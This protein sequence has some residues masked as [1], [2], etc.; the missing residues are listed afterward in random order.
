M[1]EIIVVGGG[2]G[3]YASAIR[4]SQLGAKVTLVEAAELGGTCVNRGCIP[5]K[6]WLKAA[7]VKET[8]RRAAEFGV[9][10]DFKSLNL[11]TVVAR[12]NGIGSDIRMGMQGLLANYRVNVVQG[13]A[14]FTGPTEVVVDGKTHSAD[15]V[16]LATGSKIDFPNISGLEDAALPVTQLFDLTSLPGS[17]LIPGAGVI[18]VEM[19]QLLALMGVK[20]T[21][22]AD[23]SRI[24]PGED[25]DVGQRIGQAIKAQG[26]DVVTRRK[27]AAVYPAEKGYLCDL[28]GEGECS[29]VVDKIV[30]CGR[31]PNSAGLGLET[32]G[33]R[34]AEDGAVWV[35]DTLQT[36]TRGL[37]AIGDVTGGRMLSHAASA[38]A[39]F[40]A[41]NAM[42]GSAKFP[43]HLVPR[44]L[45][46]LPEA[47][48]VGFTEEEAEACGK[49][50]KVG[51]F[52]FSINALAMTEG[53]QPGAVKVVSDAK[54][55]EILGVHIVG[56]HATELIGEAVTA[57][58]LES[59]TRELALSIRMHPT[60]SEA[61]V[62][63]ARDS[64]DWALYLPKR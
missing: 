3:G 35:D 61:V 63:A 38:M 6:V 49:E 14:E 12:K 30:L 21:L 39:V 25:S 41:Q 55:G 19:A 36:S 5:S 62:D 57:M 42:G 53:E 54:T 9:E 22:V 47:A 8:V 50:V 58:Q 17:V 52:P 32:I 18:E 44:G 45:W 4:A 24:L 1:T 33:V 59:T 7:A 31:T 13:R 37:Y 40:A 26:V 46:T 28:A 34:T 48:A 27:L 11:A 51:D 60:F 15:R 43:F 23:G 2:P 10:A 56:S 64:L 20:V 29:A 16:I